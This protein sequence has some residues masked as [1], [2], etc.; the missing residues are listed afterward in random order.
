MGLTNFSLGLFAICI[1]LL[2]LQFN[3]IVRYITGVS[4]GPAPFWLTPAVHLTAWLLLL[5]EWR[6]AN[7]TL[8]RFA[9]A[10]LVVEYLLL[11][12]G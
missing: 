5:S 7:S 2:M 8:R 4:N 12:T 6:R 1:T 3:S 11:I 10:V 9:I